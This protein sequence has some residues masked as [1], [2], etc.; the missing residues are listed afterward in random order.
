MILADKIIKHR[1]RNGW[2]QEELAWK[3]SVSRQAVSKWE[4]A[5]SIP[6]LD[7]ILL[8]AELFGVTTDYLLKDEIEDDELSDETASDIRRVSLEEANKYLD[9]R[10]RASGR[11]AIAILLCILSPV[12]LFVMMTLSELEGAVI[13]ENVAGVI[14][15]IALF[16][17]IFYAVQIFI[18]QGFKNQPY[19]FLESCTPFELQYG[20][21]GVVTER[22]EAFREKYIRSNIAAACLCLISPLPL[23]IT[24][25]FNNDFLSELMVAV[26]FLAVGTGVYIFTSVGIVMASMDKL[27]KEGDYTDEKKKKNKLKESVGF[28]YWGIITAIFL[29]VS[30]ACDGWNYSWLIFAIGGILFPVAMIICDLISAKT[31]KNDRIGK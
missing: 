4:S 16:G 6:E 22:R 24:G 28:S 10:K 13:T 20:V 14:G 25:F 19:E 27:L 15:M 5:Q 9:E 26:L 8:L 7:K 31:N 18:Y 11:I 23:I 1:K 12:T 21:R 29:V 3:M 30:F 2:S 17:F